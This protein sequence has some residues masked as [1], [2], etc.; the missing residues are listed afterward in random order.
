VLAVVTEPLTHR[1]TG[2]GSDVLHYIVFGQRLP[3]R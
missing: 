2:E 1:G 3:L